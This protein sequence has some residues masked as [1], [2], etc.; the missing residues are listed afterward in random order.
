MDDIRIKRA[1][2]RQPAFELVDLERLVPAEHRV[3]DVWAFV[4]TLDLSVFHDRIKAR[5]ETAGR[6]AVD[7]C[8]LLALWLYAT[9]EGVGS[10]RALDR[11]CEHH[12]I[13]RWICGGV[14]VNHELLR[15]FRNES[16]AF[17]DR[18]LTQSLTALIE[19]GLLD[20]DEMI[21][22]GTKVRASASRSSMRRAP[23]VAEIET[24]VKARIATLRQELDAD[25]QATERR[26]KSRLLAAAEERAR[27][28]SAALTKFTEREA[29]RMK[30]ARQHPG[31]A[32][33]RAG[34]D[35]PRVS[36]SDPDARLMKMA[37]GA[38]RVCYNVQVGTA[39]EFIVAIQPTDHGNDRNLAPAVVAE[40]ERRTGR[41]PSR[42]LADG[43]AMTEEDIVGFAASHPTLEVFAPPK[44]CS[45]TAKPASRARYERKLAREARC[46][47]DWRARMAGDAG[48]AV[49]ARRSNTEHP[50]ARMKNRGFGR[51]LVRG[52]EKVRTVCLLHAV[53]HNFVLA[54]ARRAARAGLAAG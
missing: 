29:E 15:N 52:L 45:E 28:V 12:L 41:S 20:M 48:K 35:G 8:I 44:A 36:T 24:E 26:R 39:G 23:R 46:L 19:E 7:P 1:D 13:Y 54:A 51:M 37:D 2:R 27:R 34:A 33:E 3:R 50:H 21:T 40:A 43:T 47:R 42:L 9:I 6:P 25:P 4:E 16:G 10:A 32:A 30:R 38:M 49:Y 5:G 11:L 31:E 53:A 17:L 14:G 18:L 22:D